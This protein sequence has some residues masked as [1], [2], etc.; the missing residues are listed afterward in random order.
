M[1]RPLLRRV[2]VA[3]WSPTTN[4]TK[5]RFEKFQILSLVVSGPWTCRMWSWWRSAPSR[6]PAT[7]HR[8]FFKA[9]RSETLIHPWWT[10][11]MCILLWSRR[12]SGPWK[13]RRQRRRAGRR[14]N[15]FHLVAATKTNRKKSKR[16]RRR[17]SLTFPS[18][19]KPTKWKIWMKMWRTGMC[20]GRRPL[21][22]RSSARTRKTKAKRRRTKRKGLQWRL[23]PQSPPPR[24]P[25]DRKRSR[26]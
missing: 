6:V 22:T 24:R 16:T 25:H 20:P 18:G 7:P 21:W 2:A 9:P 3:L 13:H 10:R 19:M 1:K 12:R 8:C 5:R 17:Q 26:N 23:W 4:S 14:R 11:A 15:G